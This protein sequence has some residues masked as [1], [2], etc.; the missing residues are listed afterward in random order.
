MVT[1]ITVKPEVA[2]PYRFDRC[3]E[4]GDPL[5]PEARL[6][7]LCPAC[8][9]PSPTPPEARRHPDCQEAR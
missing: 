2:P 8:V 3:D 1:S 6:W 7:G 4:C 5:E 9:T